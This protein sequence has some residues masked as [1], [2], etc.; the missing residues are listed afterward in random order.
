MKRYTVTQFGVNKE[1]NEYR[2]PIWEGYAESK[3][4]AIDK[5]VK[6]RWR[7]PEMQDFMKGY[8]KA[9]EYILN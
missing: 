5:A 8:M 6:T 2:E 3:E 4:D 1:F 9:V 7:D